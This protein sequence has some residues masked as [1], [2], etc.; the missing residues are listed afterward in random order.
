[1]SDEKRDENVLF[2]GC[3]MPFVLVFAAWIALGFLLVWMGVA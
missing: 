2:R 1:M 3:I